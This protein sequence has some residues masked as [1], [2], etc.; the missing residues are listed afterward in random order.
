MKAVPL[1]PNF[2]I[3][4]KRS[5]TSSAKHLYFNLKILEANKSPSPILTARKSSI[6]APTIIWASP[7]IPSFAAPPLTPH[8]NSASAPVLSALSPAL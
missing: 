7:R 5:K 4:M 1:V 8:A 6:S 3:C 2:S